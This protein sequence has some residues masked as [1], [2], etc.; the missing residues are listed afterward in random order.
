MARWKEPHSLGE[1]QNNSY[2]ETYRLFKVIALGYDGSDY[3]P[4]PAAPTT[5]TF[6]NVTMTT[7][8]QEYSQALPAGTKRVDIKLRSLSAV[9]KLSFTSTESGTKYISV[10]YG[11]LYSLQGVNLTGAT[12]YFQSIKAAQT[13]EIICWT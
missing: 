8:N 2:D 7:A 12:L 4:L 11:S 3:A 13:A 6:Y 5:P 10:P 1:L 9:L